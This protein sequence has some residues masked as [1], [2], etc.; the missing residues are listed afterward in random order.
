MLRCQSVIRLQVAMA[1]LEAMT[2]ALSVQDLHDAKESKNDSS[3]LWTG[4]E[5][6]AH[7]P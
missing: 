4:A 6:S 3:D 1:E 7:D 5:S 2:S